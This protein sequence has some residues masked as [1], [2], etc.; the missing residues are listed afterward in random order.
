M[1]IAKIKLKSKLKE[2]LKLEDSRTLTAC[3]ES[4]VVSICA[5]SFLVSQMLIFTFLVMYTLNKRENVNDSLLLAMLA[6]PPCLQSF[7]RARLNLS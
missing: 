3:A 7:C 6:I 1:E 4:R 5:V 2:A